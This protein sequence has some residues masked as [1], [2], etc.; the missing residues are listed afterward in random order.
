L[1]R[2][3]VGSLNCAHTVR[4]VVAKTCNNRPTA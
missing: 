3:R 4:A 1:I 2:V